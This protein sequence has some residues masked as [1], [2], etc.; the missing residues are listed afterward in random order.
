MHS[1]SV[2]RS[3]GTALTAT[4]DCVNA[5]HEMATT[6]KLW[7]TAKDCRDAITPVESG[8]TRSISF[9]DCLVGVTIQ[10]VGRIGVELQ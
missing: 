8:Q 4:L 10:L 9:E 3:T 2:K 7:L 5:S 1:S 6:K